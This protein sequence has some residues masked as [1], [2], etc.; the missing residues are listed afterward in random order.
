MIDKISVYVNDSRVE[1]RNERYQYQKI[2]TVFNQFVQLNFLIAAKIMD[3]GRDWSHNLS[4][5]DVR[6]NWWYVY[7]KWIKSY[8]QMQL[9]SQ[10]HLLAWIHQGHSTEMAIVQ[11]TWL[12]CWWLCEKPFFLLSNI[13]RSVYHDYFQVIGIASRLMCYYSNDR[14]NEWINEWSIILITVYGYPSNQVHI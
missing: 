6:M 3:R 4:L 12:N 14:I 5:Q 11:R 8:I 13:F 1:S 2:T 9:V 7:K 10:H